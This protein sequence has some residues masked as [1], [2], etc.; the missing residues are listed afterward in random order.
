MCNLFSSTSGVCGLT[1]WQLYEKEDLY[2]S[3]SQICH[4][5][6]DLPLLLSFTGNQGEKMWIFGNFVHMWNARGKTYE[7]WIF[8]CFAT[9]LTLLCNYFLSYWLYNGFMKFCVPNIAEKR[10]PP[11]IIFDR[12]W[13][14]PPRRIMD[15]KI[16]VPPGENTICKISATWFYFKNYNYFLD[17]VR[18]HPTA[19][20]VPKI[21][22]ILG[23]F[24]Y[25][26]P[27]TPP[28]ERQGKN[29]FPYSHDPHP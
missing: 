15:G 12:V 28:M 16:F 21:C 4:F 1:V 20:F 26:S 13:G 8:W 27:K 23:I 7:F 17:A 18:F 2:N 6:L 10:F 19:V 29:Y 5:R 14:Y 3:V 11:C 25:M 9:V 24:Q 22:Q